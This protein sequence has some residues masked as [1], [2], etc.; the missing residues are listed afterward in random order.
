MKPGLKLLYLQAH[1]F[2]PIQSASNSIRLQSPKNALLAVFLSSKKQSMM[3]SSGA[4][5]VFHF[6]HSDR[7]IFYL[8]SRMTHLF[9]GKYTV[10]WAEGTDATN[11][12]I[13]RMSQ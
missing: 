5:S 11:V 12:S 4:G 3:N 9:N 13:A 6:R 10:D 8:T 2:T 1:T 7:S